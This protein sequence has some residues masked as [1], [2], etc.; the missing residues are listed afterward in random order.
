M[1]NFITQHSLKIIILTLILSL[2]AMISPLM[3]NNI[4]V[5]NTS[6]SGQTSWPTSST[7]FTSCGLNEAPCSCLARQSVS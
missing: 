7:F 4:Q 3:A 1:K 6:V 2:I 5:A